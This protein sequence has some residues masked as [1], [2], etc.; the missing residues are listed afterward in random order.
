[1]DIKLFKTYNYIDEIKKSLKGENIDLMI[2]CF[3]EHNSFTYNI[4][5]DIV[6]IQKLYN[7]MSKV[8]EDFDPYSHLIKKDE[9]IEDEDCLLRFGD[10]NKKMKKL[11][12]IYFSLP[13]GYTCPFANICKSFA[14]KTGG[15]FKSNQK[16]I[17]DEGD[18]RCYAANTEMI[19][20]VARENRWRNL[21]LINKFKTVDEIADLISRSIHYYEYTHKKISLL[22]MHES[23]DFFNQKYFD[24]WMKVADERKDIL[25]YGYTKAIPFLVKRLN[26]LPKNFRLI[27]SVGGK[28]DKLL[29]E[30]PEI[31]KA[32]IVDSEEEAIKRKLRIDI[33]DFLAVGGEEDFAL[34]LHGVQSK[35]SGKSN[36]A[37]QN[38]LITKKRNKVLKTDRQI[39]KKIAQKYT[40]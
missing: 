17:K 23:G 6:A 22:R 32:F 2:E 29:F 19:Y 4:K 21:D 16:S 31:R 33:N 12:I 40:S 10:S 11:D 9:I 1:M 27:G 37:R 28:H 14:H 36:V 3:Y 13:A 35:E 38:S 39:L 30:H 5:N 34:L 20:K 8:N 26:V 7:L 25:F 18:I 15:K 24:A